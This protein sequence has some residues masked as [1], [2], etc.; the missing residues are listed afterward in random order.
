MN[1]VYE[2]LKKAGNYFIATT[3][4]SQPRVRPFASVNVFEG[5]LYFQTGRVK[6]VSKQIAANPQIE[7]CAFADGAWVRVAA[8][9]VEDTNIEAAISMLEAVPV[10]KDLYKPGD[11]NCQVFYLKDATATFY[12]FGGEP[13]V[14]TF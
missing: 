14:I 11:G 10:L 1:E 5:K 3:E 7:I 13:R 6:E 12:S 4:G 8:T 9:A 2:F